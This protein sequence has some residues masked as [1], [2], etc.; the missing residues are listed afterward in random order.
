MKPRV[1][2]PEMMFRVRREVEEY[3]RLSRSSMW[4]L[5]GHFVRR[6]SRAG[7]RRGRVLDVGSGTGRLL[8]ALGSQA[9]VELELFGVDVS[10]EMVRMALE[11]ARSS[12]LKTIPAIQ[13]ASAARLPYADGSF[14]LVVSSSSL[15]LWSDPVSVLNEIRRVMKK[16]GVCLIRDGRRLPDNFIWRAFFWLSSRMMGMNSNERDAWKKAIEAGY[17][18]GETRILLERSRFEDWKVRRD[19]MLFELMIEAR[20]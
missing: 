4:P 11:S 10:G 20:T 13:I 9:N 5:Y 1:P 8:V 7:I 12:C 16:G 15:H 19:W 3:D 17:T 6:I 14:D 2:Q 18:L